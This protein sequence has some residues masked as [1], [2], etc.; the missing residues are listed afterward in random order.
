MCTETYRAGRADK[1]RHVLNDA[2]DVDPCSPTESKLSCHIINSNHLWCGYQYSSQH[3]CLPAVK[4]TIILLS[5]LLKEFQPRVN[6]F[7]LN[8]T[9]QQN[10][11]WMQEINLGE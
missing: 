7:H 6:S 5:P 10:G 2:K 11:K 9:T 3:W 8:S 1:A 4:I